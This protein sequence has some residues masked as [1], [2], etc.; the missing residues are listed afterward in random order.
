M[1]ELKK[2]GLIYTYLKLW[3]ERVCLQVTLPVDL[4]TTKAN[5]EGCLFKVRAMDKAFQIL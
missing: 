5:F 2:G 1:H 4:F 3:I